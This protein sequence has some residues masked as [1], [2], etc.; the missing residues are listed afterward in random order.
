MLM[1]L[2]APR[3]LYIAS[4]E[5]DRESDPR[6]EFLAAVAASPVWNLYGK[7]GIATD[8]M[9]D[10]HQPVGDLVTYHIRSGKHDVTAYDWEQYFR[11]AERHLPL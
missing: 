8:R 4:A 10:L 5:L 9:P 1:A 2:M 3:P 7:K 11:F 6:G